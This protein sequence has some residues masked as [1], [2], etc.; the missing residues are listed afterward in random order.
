MDLLG[1]GGT[2]NEGGF[3]PAHPKVRKPLSRLY[4]F[5]RIV[6]KNSSGGFPTL[7]MNDGAVAHSNVENIRSDKVW[8]FIERCWT[9]YNEATAVD[10]RAGGPGLR[11]VIVVGLR[12]KGGN[13]G[14]IAQEDAL[15]VIIDSLA[16]GEINRDTAVAE[17]R[18][19]RRIFD[20]VPQLQAISHLPAHMKQ[21]PPDP[22]RGFPV[23]TS[24]STRPS[25]RTASHR[26]SGRGQPFLGGQLRHRFPRPLC[27][28]PKST[29]CRS[30]RPAPH[31]GQASS[32]ARFSITRVV[33]AISIDVLAQAARRHFGNRKS[34]PTG[35]GGRRRECSPITLEGRST[36]IVGSGKPSLSRSDQIVASSRRRGIY[37][38]RL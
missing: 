6:S 24:F 33:A 16:S 38:A 27:H 22:L 4:S 28:L 36:R 15:T 5:Q 10:A 3:D 26:G 32:G 19:V 30:R 35:S 34:S 25:S 1:Y 17:A 14:I 31:S 21:R 11:A 29:R 7:V 18:K 23:P 8:R 13:R 37:A 20:I 12:A 9:L 2:I